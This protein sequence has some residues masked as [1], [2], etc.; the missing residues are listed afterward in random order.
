MKNKINFKL[1][2]TLILMAIIYIFINTSG[3]WSGIILK[4]VNIILPFFFAFVLAYILHPFVKKLEDKG[5]RRSLALTTVIIFFFM[6]IVGLL[7][8]TLP[9]IYDQLVSFSKTITKALSNISGNL[10]LDLGDYQETITDA[11]NQLIKNMGSYISTGTI[12]ILGKSV[13][14]LTDMIIVFMVGVYFL[15]DM[16]K[17]REF[18]KKYLRRFKR[19]YDYVKALDNEMGKYLH[20]LAIFMLIQLVEYSLLF[21]IIGH[22]SWLLLGVLACVTTVI[23]YFGGLITNIIACITASVVSTKLFVLTLIITL[24][25]PNIDGYVISPHVYGKTNNINPILVIF[26]AAICSS[27][28]GILGIALGLPLYLIIRTTWNFFNEDI[29]GYIGD[30]KEESKKKKKESKA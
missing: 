6:I 8:F 13:N 12:D 1:L 3:Y 15:I 5:I 26:V 20:G 11:L 7:W 14:F 16:D 24:I 21:R 27:L 2:N 10:D 29:K 17:I 19:E 18:I 22:P 23:P 25:F 28:F 30:R 4:I 9:A